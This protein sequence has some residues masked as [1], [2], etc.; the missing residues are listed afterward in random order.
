M[1]LPDQDTIVTDFFF[2]YLTLGLSVFLNHYLR[3]APLPPSY[4]RTRI[5]SRPIQ[6][7]HTFLVSRMRR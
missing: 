6:Q 1:I 2:M 4:A 3:R 5:F 7:H